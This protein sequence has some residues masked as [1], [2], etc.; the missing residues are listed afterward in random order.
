M[1]SYD[2]NN[3]MY[4]MSHLFKLYQ[5]PKSNILHYVKTKKEE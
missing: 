3:E 2:E 5:K 4:K 1:G